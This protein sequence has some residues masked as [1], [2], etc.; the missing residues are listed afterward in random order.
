MP[1]TP[2]PTAEHQRLAKDGTRRANWKRWG[3]YLSERQWGTVR[4]DYSPDGNVWDAVPHDHARS[5]A[6]RWGE[7][8]LLGWTDRQCRLSFGVALWNG[9]DAIL[10]ERLFGLTGHEGNHGEDV[11]ELYYYLDATPTYSYVRGLYKYPQDEFPYD[12]LVAENGRRSQHDPELELHQLGVFDLGR[13]FDVGIEYAKGGPDDTLIRIRVTNRS[14]EP[15][16]IHVLPQLWFRNTWVW[17]CKHE[18]CTLKPV[19]TPEGAGRVM[20]DHETLGKYAWDWVGGQGETEAD[21]PELLLT[22]NLTNRELLYG[23]ENAGPF[24]KDAFHRRVIHGD[25]AA[26]SDRGHGTKAAWWRKLDLPA[27]GAQVIRLRL[28]LDG[29][30]SAEQARDVEA[31]DA[32]FAERK[33]EADAFYDA[34]LDEP[35]GTD[36]RRVARQ[37]LAGVLWSKQFYHY[38]VN[39]WIDGDPDTTPPPAERKQGRNRDWR[40]FFAR[41]VLSMPDKWEYPWFAAWDTAFHTLP[42]AMV[43]PDD[44]RRHLGLFLR[45]WYMHPNGQLPAYEFAF[46]DVNPPVHAWAVWRIYKMCGPKAKRDKAWLASCFQKLLINFTWWVNRKDPEGDHVFSGGFLGLDNIGV[47]D[48]SHPPEGL[49]NMAQSDGTAWMAFF[50]GTMLSIALELADHGPGYEDMASKF[51]EHFVAISQAINSDEQGMGLWHEKDGFY[52]DHL[53]FKGEDGH[54][55]V[56]LRSLVGLMPLIAAEVYDEEKLARLPG[57][58]KRMN[59]FLGNSP[60]AASQVRFS[61]PDGSIDGSETRVEAGRGRRVLLALPG[62]ER[63]RRVLGYVFDPKEFLSPYGVRSL[64]KRYQ[65]KPYRMKI[66]GVTQEVRY[67]PAESDTQMFGGNSNW[68]GPVWFPLNYLLVEALERYDHF[69]GPSF[70]VEAP[71]G[72]GQPVRLLDAALELERRLTSLFLPGED[73]RAPALVDNQPQGRADFDGLLQFHEYFDGDTGRGC[74]AAHQT[75]WTA[76]VARC[77]NELA[78]LGRDRDR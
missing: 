10:K 68:R 35:A 20:A 32:I 43:D 40:H 46:G 59:W 70:T 39:D 57:F 42:L 18:G 7:D 71:T 33:A 31:F 76:L 55:P 15:A 61:S 69:Y 47:F 74:G 58:A 28:S 34:V 75:G 72:S 9:K 53:R 8:G 52:Y 73:G 65:D 50:C 17:G 22:E 26:V 27:G 11:K 4:E 51:F 64:S 56:R 36:R 41:D 12:R 6:Y 54:R 3:T 1:P 2:E 60:A 24:V 63:L 29:E 25:T 5:L 13:Y 67:Q 23:S 16:S 49:E 45:E 48:R 62:P 78:Q 37:A 44:A 30:V 66:H 38:V 21:V 19:L 14:T 77:V